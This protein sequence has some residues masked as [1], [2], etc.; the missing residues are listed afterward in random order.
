MTFPVKRII[1]FIQMVE[2]LSPYSTF[3]RPSS[4]TGSD[5]QT[6]VPRAVTG[7]LL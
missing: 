4:A 1:L 2:T 3:V 6:P 7:L 5:L